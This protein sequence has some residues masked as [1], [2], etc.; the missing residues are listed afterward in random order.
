[1]NILAVQR[2]L[3]KPGFEF[4]RSKKPTRWLQDQLQEE[5]VTGNALRGGRINVLETNGL[6]IELLRESRLH[7]A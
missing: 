7:D 2:G 1:M 3:N 6:G 5:F 4:D